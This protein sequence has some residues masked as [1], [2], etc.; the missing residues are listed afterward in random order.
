M[1]YMVDRRD[2]ERCLTYFAT[3][4]TVDYTSLFGGEESTVAATDLIGGWR[5]LVP[6]FDVTQHFATN[7]MVHEQG[8]EASA[9]CYVQGLHYLA[10]EV[11]TPWWKVY[12]YYHF[13]LK[14]IAG[15]WQIH[16]MRLE[17]TMEEGD[18]K[19]TE[20]AAAKV[21]AQY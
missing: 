21:A 16:Y 4:V 8:E 14:R 2:W 5:Q 11:T 10:N 12:G 9:V 18:R 13:G 19:L 15:R 17:A 20:L 6:G 1:L 3:K 7:F